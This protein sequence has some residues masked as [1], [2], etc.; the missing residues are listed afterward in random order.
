MIN[1]AKSGATSQVA[2]PDCAE[3]VI[4]RAFSPSVGSIGAAHLRAKRQIVETIQADLP[5]G[6]SGDFPVQPHLQKYFVSRLTQ[7]KSIS[8]AVSPHRGAYRD[9]HGRGAGCGGRGRRG[10]T[11]RADADGEVVWS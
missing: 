5:D 1:A 2:I 8:L 11:N 6:P 4:G 3:P 9:R 10:L 7:I